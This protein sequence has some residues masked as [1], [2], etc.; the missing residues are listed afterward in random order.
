MIA[1]NKLS[2]SSHHRNTHDYF[3]KFTVTKHDFGHQIYCVL[4]IARIATPVI[5]LGSIL[6][7]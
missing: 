3:A 6:D 5:K 2:R 1:S 7:R 4:H